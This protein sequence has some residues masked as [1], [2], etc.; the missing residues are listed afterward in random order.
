MSSKIVAFLFILVSSNFAQSNAPIDIPEN[1]HPLPEVGFGTPKALVKVVMYHSLTCH[2]CIDFKLNKLPILQQKYI[3]SGRLYFVL[4]DFPTD[5]FS[6]KLAIICWIGRDVAKYLER[7]HL[8]MVNFNLDKDKTVEFDWVN[9][10][11]PTEVIEKMLTPTGI[12]SSVIQPTFDDKSIEDAILHD[13]LIAGRDL[14]LNFAPGF[15]VNGKL[16]EMKDLDE[17]IEDALQEASKKNVLV[18]KPKVTHQRNGLGQ[19]LKAAAA[20]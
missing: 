5:E 7:S 1:T 2:H 12:S 16:V 18:D 6:L 3:D 10:E 20:A 13:A 8:I 14:K 11:H 9:A 17:A 15:T 4:K 19:S